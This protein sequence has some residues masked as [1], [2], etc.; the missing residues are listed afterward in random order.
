MQNFN[1]LRNKFKGKSIL[2]KNRISS[3]TIIYK[4]KIFKFKKKNQ[5]F[6]RSNKY[7]GKEQVLIKCSFRTSGLKYFSV[8]ESSFNR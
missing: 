8:S 3:D 6:L 4:K 7:F 5:Y 1:E 2:E